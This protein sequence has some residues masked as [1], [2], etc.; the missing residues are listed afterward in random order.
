MET[1]PEQDKQVKLQGWQS[2]LESGYLPRG[3]EVLQVLLSKKNNAWELRGSQ[4]RQLVGPEL[5]QFKQEESQRRQTL[6]V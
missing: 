6:L 1:G 2:L 5:E 4:E 3:Q